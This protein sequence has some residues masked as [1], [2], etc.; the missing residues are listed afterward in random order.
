MTDSV[1]GFLKPGTSDHTVSNFG[2]LDQMAALQWVKDNIA[3]FGGDMGSVTLFG[4]S[5]GA[6]CVNLLM[7][8]PVARGKKFDFPIFLSINLTINSFSNCSGLFHRAILMS[9]SALSDWAISRH[10]LQATMQLLNQLN[11]PL[12]DENEEM[13]LCLRK[14]RYQDIV[15]AEVQTPAF[16][17]VFGPVVDNHVVLNEPH[18]VM[19]QY[20]D[21]FSR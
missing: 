21:I 18:H 2:L 6:A 14:K 3:S 8:S 9:G 10:P 12:R 11:C 20:A 19:S 4:H 16:T 7:L 1:L 13:L 15:N 5:T 17:T